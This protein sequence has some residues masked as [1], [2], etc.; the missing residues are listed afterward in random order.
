LRKA[1][2]LTRARDSVQQQQTR[3]EKELGLVPE[4]PT[5]LAES[6][7]LS[8]I[9]A[10]V[11]GIKDNRVGFITKH[12]DDPRVVAAVLGAPAF[13]S[14]LTDAEMGVVKSEIAKRVNPKLAASKD[15][16]LSALADVERGW[17]NASNQIRS[18]A[19]LE[20]VGNGAA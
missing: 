17:R 19:G 13:L 6:V 4:Q 5:T 11:A 16:A 3:W 1:T 20:K 10:H 9:R 2:S 14:G 12:A 18:R 8:E 15:E 7:Q